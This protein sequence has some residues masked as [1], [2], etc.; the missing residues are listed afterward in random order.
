M[1]EA[2]EPLILQFSTLAKYHYKINT[3]F[4]NLKLF[5]PLDFHVV[6]PNTAQKP[7]TQV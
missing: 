4:G 5:F 6:K 7:L 1:Y 2:F 3:L